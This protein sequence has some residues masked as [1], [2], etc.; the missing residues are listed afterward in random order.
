MK[1]VY[2]NEGLSSSVKKLLSYVINKIHVTYVIYKIDY[3]IF[4]KFF[5]VDDKRYR[6]FIN[7]YNSVTTERVVEIPFAKE[8]VFKNI[9]KNVL[10]VG[11]VL[12]H[13]LSVNY[14]IVDK[15][16]KSLHVINVDII[17]F[18][19]EKKYDLIISISTIEHI[20][21]DETIKKIGK[22]K[23]A[24]LKIVSLL[25]I[26]G[27]AVI[28]V[29]L[30]YNPEIDSIIMNDEIRF[31]K[32]LFLK[33]VNKLNLWEETTM[34]DALKYKYGQK[35]PTANAIAFLLYKNEK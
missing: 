13:Y 2:R 23:E 25:N 8:F 17:E 33:R 9:G 24:M 11:N 4:N 28:T 21:F 31:S 22:S 15:Y 10:E 19:S 29:P 20:G 34:E 6:Y 35:Y 30:G 18:N 3:T 16:E 27:I 7:T 1:T 5:I 32:K 26:N 14:D 12:S